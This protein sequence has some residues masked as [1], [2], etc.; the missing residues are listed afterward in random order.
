V[1]LVKTVEMRVLAKA[2]DAQAKLDALAAEADK[3]QSDGIKMRFRVDDGR[4]KAQLDEIRAQ[5][6]RLGLKDVSIK[7]RVDGKGRAVADLAAIKAEADSLSGGGGGIL[8]RIGGLLGGAGGG[9]PGALGP[10]PL[11]AL[12]AA[13]PVIGA[14]ATELVGVAAGFAAAGAGAGAFALLAAPAVKHV[15]TAYQALNAAQ[16][17]YQQALLKEQLS[18]SKANQSALTAAALNLKIA[19]EQLARLPASEQAAVRGIQGLASEFG[20]MSRAFEPQAFKVFADGLKVIGNLLPHITPFAT[21]FAQGLDK[22]LQQAAKFTASKGFSDWLK[23]FHSLEGPAI[24]SIGDGI[25]KVANAFGKLLTTVSGKD[26]AHSLNILFD[27]VAGTINV[28]AS[29]IHR[30]MQNFDGM[31]AAATTAVRAVSSAFRTMAAAVAGAVSM[32]IRDWLAMVHG[33]EA[34]V[35]AAISAASK[36]PGRIRALFAGA[37]GWLVQAGQ[38]IIMGLIHGIESMVGKVASAIGHIASVIRSFLPFSPAKEGP[39]SGS[40]SPDIA[41]LKVATMFAAGINSGVRGVALAAGRLAGAASV[42]PA[43]AGYGH[44]GV[45]I[46]FNGVVGDKYGTAQVI[47]QVMRDYKRQRG[48]GA[49]GLG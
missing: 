45:V 4:A 6:D 35:S 26:V 16:Q 48:G 1:A 46:N 20:K 41:G 42:T 10:V 32:V 17:K 36:L 30:F 44:G 28:T 2:G 22:L 8:S 21:T 7:V 18:P 15:E 47:H 27:G 5:A 13:V 43:M 23:Q 38:N 12:A 34:G 49:L 24:Q 19:Q 3:L 31:K 37:G 39:L 9:I 14:L 29:A 40:G 25:G 11:P 33:I